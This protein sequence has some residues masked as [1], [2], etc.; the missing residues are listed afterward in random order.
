MTGES[1]SE[2][3]GIGG[4]EGER[5]KCTAEKKKKKKASELKRDYFQVQRSSFWLFTGCHS[6]PG[7]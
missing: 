4:Q 1:Q 7:S 6:V 3:K 2:A 5:V